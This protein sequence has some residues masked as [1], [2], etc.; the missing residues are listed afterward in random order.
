MNQN[1]NWI[2]NKEEITSI[3]QMPE[4]VYGFIYCIEYKDGKKYI[5]KKNLYSVRTLKALKSG[6]CRDNTI[7]RVYKNTGKGYRQGYDRVRCESNWLT[8]KGSREKTHKS[9]VN[10]KHILA[11]AFSKYQLTY[12]E[13]YYQFKYQVL[14]DNEFL[15][16]NILGKFYREKVE[17][18]P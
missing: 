17:K 5:G 16:D 15:N 4:K 10:K 13:T 18:T 1:N 9:D 11:Y 2:Y 14:E 6:K 7:E 12:L 8:Y 3:K